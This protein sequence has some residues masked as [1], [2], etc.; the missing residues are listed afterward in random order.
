MA[1]KPAISDFGIYGI[2]NRS[3]GKL[4]VGSAVNFLK[5]WRVH[6]HLLCSQK[7]DNV[8]LQ[9]AFTLSPESFEFFVIEKLQD[10]TALI[11]REQFWMDFY[12]SNNDSLGYNLRKKA[13]SQLGHKWNDA[14]RLRLS[15]AQKGKKRGKKTPLTQEHKDRIRKQREGTWLSG[16]N[17]GMWGR[18]Q[19]PESMARRTILRRLKKTYGKQII[20]LGMD[21]VEVA[22]FDSSYAASRHFNRPYGVIGHCA[23]GRKK[24]A[25]GFKW[26]Y[27]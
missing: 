5:R 19:K 16:E 15:M 10:R 11:Q 4:Y 14:S 9:R 20:Q 7:H 12:K 25:Y 6:S 1:Y 8:F 3:N 26:K 23:Q 2:L 27:A 13:S 17:H 24:S 21:G 22:R 18:K